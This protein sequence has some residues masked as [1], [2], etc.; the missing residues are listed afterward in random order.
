MDERQIVRNI[1]KLRQNQKISLEQLAKNAGLTKGYVSKI[2]NA[3]KAPP[4]STLIKIGRAL[5]VG[6][7]ALLADE[8]EPP[9]EINLCIV[10]RNEGKEVVSKG[11]LPGY[12][13]ISLAY[14]KMDKSM[15]PYIIE[16]AFHEKAVFSH[17]G[18]EFMYVL[19]GTH[20]FVYAGKKY[21]LRKG[22]SIYFNSRIPHSGR[23]VGKKQA[24]ILTVT[25]P[26]LLGW[27][28]E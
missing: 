11:T 4:V 17:E 7:D 14:K 5:N 24:K 15:E 23:S 1:K 2:E 16:P 8:S 22:D 19:E 6:M 27:Q 12:N 20:E 26:P 28:K 18:E 25:M 13:Y 9:E 10:K 3:H 21:L